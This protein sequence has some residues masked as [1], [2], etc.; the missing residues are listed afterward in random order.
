[1]NTSLQKTLLNTFF[2]LLTLI[3]FIAKGQN[4][5]SLNGTVKT[6]DGK[7]AEF[8]TVLITP[9]NRKAMTNEKGDFRFNRLP[10]GT[11]KV[12][13]APIG[14]QPQEKEV[15]LTTGQSTSLAFELPES[16]KDL[17]EVHILASKSKKLASKKTEY[18]A[19][20]PLENLENPQVYSVVSKELMKEQ[21]AIDIKSAVLN[22]PGAVAY[23]YP[24][25][26][27]GIAF[28]GFMSSP[29]A[30]N[31]METTATRSSLDLSNVERIEVL[32]GPSGT[33]FGASVSSFGGVVNL[34][35]KKPFDTTGVELSYT[36]GSY[37][38]NRLAADVNTPLNKDKSVLFRVNV[39]VNKEASF[40]SYGFNNT[41]TI[42]PSLTYKSSDKLT[43]N[44]DAELF[45]ANSTRRTYNTYKLNTGPTNPAELQLDYKT[46]MFHDDNDGKTSASKVFAQ[47]EYEIS[48]NWKSTTLFSFVGEDVD[49]SYQ[50]YA[51]WLSPVKMVRQVGLWG[52]ISNNYTNIQEN[53]NGQFST[54]G[55]K[56]KFL[57]G[58]TYRFYDGSRRAG[59]NVVTLDTLADVTKTFAPIRRKAVDAKMPLYT[60]AIADQETIS[61]YASDVVSVTDRLSAMLSLR[62]DR[63]ERRKVGNTAG[64]KQTS[65]S[66]KLGLV[67]Q[68]IKDQV[69]LFGNYMNGFQNLAPVNQ[70]DGSVL[71]L[72]PVYAVQYEGGVKAE[73][74]D[75]K[76]SATASYYNI[77]IDNA[78]RTE[79][80]FTFQDGKQRSKGIDLE[81]IG[82][83]VAGL[84]IVA[85]YAYNDNRIV[86]SSNPAIEGNKAT[87]SPESVANF[88]ASYTL[89][90]N[91]KGLGLG[92]GANYADKNFFTADNKVFIP[93][94]TVYNATLF[95]DQSKWRAGLKLNNISN[96]KYWDIGGNAQTPRSAMASLSFRF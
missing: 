56:H 3:S 81:L 77:E 13:V 93:S 11:Y 71:V 68:V 18:V 25:G 46:S 75:K 66:P 6:S 26:G 30:R 87:A 47:A 76:L 69:S 37:N 29:N 7:P 39:A 31:G 17:E 28:R 34:V 40:L 60:S 74:I 50:S 84:S 86:K 38:L 53:I 91:L 58:V 90:N 85:G 35:T 92:F 96:E 15:T 82:N 12:T 48:D 64:F 70:P 19:R 95:Y 36:G 43:F 51:E 44:F 62:L 41:Y 42:A 45:N 73:L 49:R 33:L 24:A 32:K 14:L 54:G 78:T 94:Y 2:A 9:L 27:V 83:P 59:G 16:S 57:A 52:P 65:L 63:F 22:T 72:D 67:Y 20:M 10:A 1:M 4:L 79:A 55:I 5:A 21:V 61:A 23:N 89:Q 88:W 8:V 80:N